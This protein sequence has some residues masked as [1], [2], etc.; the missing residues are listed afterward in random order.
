MPRGDLVEG[1]VIDDHGVVY[2]VPRNGRH[3]NGLGGQR[4]AEILDASA[5]AYAVAGINVKEKKTVVG[6][7]TAILWGA[8]ARGR[9]GRM[10]AARA[11]QG[12][13]AVLTA[14]LVFVG[15]GSRDLIRRFVGV[16]VAMFLY[17][18][19]LL[20]IFDACFA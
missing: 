6:A 10:G 14:E 5:R 16:W 8:E 12:D 9:A 11:R 15:F 3:T 19:P 1:V 4:A 17:R 18:R 7:S 13:L 2:K 20:A